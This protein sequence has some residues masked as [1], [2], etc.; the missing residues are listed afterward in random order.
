MVTALRCS[1]PEIPSL[2]G[3]GERFPRAGGSDTASLHI[4]TVGGTV[5]T[6]LIEAENADRRM[7]IT[8]TE[9]ARHELPARQGEPMCVPCRAEQCESDEQYDQ[10]RSEC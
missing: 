4:G 3:P 1:G 9:S 8:G 2:R 6:G 7:P 10:W 5:E